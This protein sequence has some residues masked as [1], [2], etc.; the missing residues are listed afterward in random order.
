MRTFTVLL[1]QLI[2]T[3]GGEYN[4]PDE[5]LNKHLS[6]L[7]HDSF[8]ANPDKRN[9]AK[10]TRYIMA[11]SAFLPAEDAHPAA[12]TD[13]MTVKRSYQR[14]GFAHETKIKGFFCR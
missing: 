3:R 7:Q 13:V 4:S 5:K 9:A 12:T 10:H 6:T 11:Q 1:G 8:I 14:S 2:S